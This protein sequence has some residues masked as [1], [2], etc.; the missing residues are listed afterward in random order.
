MTWED[1]F[2]KSLDSQDI[3]AMLDILEGLSTNHAST[4]TQAIKDKSLKM[5]QT[6]YKD[7][8]IDLYKTGI[9]LA[10]SSSVVGEELGSI[11]IAQNYHIN[12]KEV[13][14]V[15]YSLAD[16]TNWEVREWVASA[17]SIVLNNNFDQFYSILLGWT[18]SPS[19]NVRRAVVV[20]V[21]YSGKSREDNKAEQLLD[22]IEP[23][24][25][26]PDPYVKKNLGAFAIGDGLLRYFPSRVINRIKI[27]IKIDNEHVR[28]NIAKIF[29]SAEGTKYIEQLKEEVIAVLIS[30]QRS[31]VVRAV[32]SM[33]NTIKKRRPDVSIS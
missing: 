11:L 15:L 23:L 10:N 9:D 6:K 2:L 22:L 21:K 16:S 27:W 19:P 13:T 30:D 18:A 14:E 29:T 24:L 4:P 32:K 25:F 1:S 26:D 33:E 3:Q 7:L 12:P 31:T 8:P 17:C 28:W 20:A 5:I